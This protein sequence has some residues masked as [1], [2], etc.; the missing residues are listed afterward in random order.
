LREFMRII[1][2]NFTLDPLGNTNVISDNFLM[3]TVKNTASDFFLLLKM[4]TTTDI[5]DNLR[6]W[7]STMFSDLHGF[8]GIDISADTNYLLT[9]GFTD[10]VIDNKNAR[11]LYDNNNN[12]VMMYIF[13]DDNSV[14]ITNSEV[15][16]QQVILRIASSQIKQ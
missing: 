1:K 15:A 14:I 6:A 4:R 5:F 16:A 10:G 8:F 12:I 7:E 2:G 3:G 13:A 9:K 11:I